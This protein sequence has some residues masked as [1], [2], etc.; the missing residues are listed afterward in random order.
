MTNKSALYNFEE[1]VSSAIMEGVAVN[2]FGLVVI[3]N[4]DNF[5]ELQSM[6][7]WQNDDSLGEDLQDEY[8]FPSVLPEYWEIVDALALDGF[9]LSTNNKMPDLFWNLNNVTFDG[10]YFDLIKQFQTAKVSEQPIITEDLFADIAEYTDSDI[11]MLADT[12][13]HFEY[14]KDYAEELQIVFW[15][16]GQ[17]NQSEVTDTLPS[18]PNVFSIVYDGYAIKVQF[19]PNKVT[20]ED[21]NPIL[22][23]LR[24]QYGR[25]TEYRVLF[26]L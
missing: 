13:K 25:I 22:M 4:M 11:R 15:F 20:M 19:N 3:G 23:Q 5:A 2:D 9:I 10:L 7:Y 14:H 26:P 6:R 1:L 8:Y 21:I 12:P 24:E 17:D 16:C 18:I